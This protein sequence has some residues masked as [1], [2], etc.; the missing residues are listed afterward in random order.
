L[1]AQTTKLSLLILNKPFTPS[2]IIYILD[3]C[4]SGCLPA[5]MSALELCP[6]EIYT[7]LLHSHIQSSLSKIM[8]ELL[9]LIASTPRNEHGIDPQSR[10]TLAST[11]VLWAE[12]DKLVTLAS[13][14]LVSLATQRVEEYHSLLKDAIEELED[15]DPDEED[16]E[17][18]PDSAFPTKQ[19][20]AP[21]ATPDAPSIAPSLQALSIVPIAELR[22]RSLSI[23]RTIRVLFPALQKRR[24]STFPNVTSTTNSKSLPASTLVQGLDSIISSTQAFSEIAD[25]VAGALYE[26][27]QVQVSGRLKSLR[28]EAEACASRAKV[29]WKGVEDE[30][31]RWLEKW[32]IRLKE[33]EN[34][35]IMG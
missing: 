26:G 6:A 23:L 21:I 4:S 30:F 2:A 7:N 3:A 15:W 1:K 34:D 33:L 13:H 8:T 35:G 18:E 20:Q 14:G 24:V 9:N 17:S 10:D 5:M 31:S 12:C 19:M 29:D 27:D 25:E 16:S 32:V 11:G 22:K 28:E